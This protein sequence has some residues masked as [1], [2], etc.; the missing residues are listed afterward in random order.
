[1]VFGE[2]TILGPVSNSDTRLEKNAITI[3]APFADQAG[4]SST[5]SDLLSTS[6]RRK[7]DEQDGGKILAP[8]QILV[9]T[10]ETEEERELSLGAKMSLLL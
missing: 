1:M 6:T 7:E 5:F 9:V 4:A 3:L 8:M 2:G 10:P